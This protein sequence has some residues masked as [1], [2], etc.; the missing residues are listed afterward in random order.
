[1]EKDGCS[2]AWVCCCS[3]LFFKAVQD[4]AAGNVAAC[5]MPAFKRACLGAME[6]SSKSWETIQR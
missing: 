4:V 6:A 1:M 3:R 5:M 2:N